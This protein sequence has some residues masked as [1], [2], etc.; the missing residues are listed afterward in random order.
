[1]KRS[2]V[3]LLVWALFPA[4]AGLAAERPDKTPK[5][6]AQAAGRI[7]V[8]IQ[9]KLGVGGEKNP[10]RVCSILAVDPDTGAAETVVTEAS[11]P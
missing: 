3:P 11:D 9:A 7:F 4:L 1:M 10:Y 5:P 8:A 2:I 6:V